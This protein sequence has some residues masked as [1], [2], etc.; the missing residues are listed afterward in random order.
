MQSQRGSLELELELELKQTQ[1]AQ[2]KPM[3]RAEVY[4]RALRA[5]QKREESRAALW[6]MSAAAKT[7][8]MKL[9]QDATLPGGVSLEAAFDSSGIPVLQHKFRKSLM[10]TVGCKPRLLTLPDDATR[11]TL[12]KRDS[13]A[14]LRASVDDM[15]EVGY[16]QNIAQIA[17][18]NDGISS[19]E[20]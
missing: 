20:V 15:D 2:Q 10:G 7:A 6:V 12:S 19:K 9:L 5:S 18:I 11:L 13:K 14:E 1:M 17:K 3:L 16:S 8:P 4:A